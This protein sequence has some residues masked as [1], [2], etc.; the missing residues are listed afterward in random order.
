MSVTTDLRSAEDLA[1]RAVRCLTNPDQTAVAPA[2]VQPLIELLVAATN[3]SSNPTS[4]ARDTALMVLEHEQ[5]RVAQA[6]AKRGER[7]A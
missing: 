6:A 3:N 5:E 7:V 4:G 1:D 2:L